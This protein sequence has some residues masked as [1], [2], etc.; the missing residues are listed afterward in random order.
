MLSLLCLQFDQMSVQAS[1]YGDELRIVKGDVAEVNRLISR[2]Q[3]EIEAVKAQV[4]S[5]GILGLVE[6]NFLHDLDPAWMI[7]CPCLPSA[8][9]SGEPAGRGGGA[10]RAGCERSQSPEQRPGG[11]PAEGQTR[12]GQTAPRVSGEGGRGVGRQKRAESR[13]KVQLSGHY[14]TQDCTDVAPPTLHTQKMYQQIFKF[15][16]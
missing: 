5:Q 9:Q 2:L 10:W 6:R 3:S 8:W 1:Q 13:V 4:Q 15:F 16:N 7:S 12:H 14:A 11:R